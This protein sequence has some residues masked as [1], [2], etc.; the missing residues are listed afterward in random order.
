LS[1]MLLSKADAATLE[2]IGDLIY[3][4]ERSLELRRRAS[5]F[6]R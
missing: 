5:Y 4:D 6:Q 3:D 1:K 2:A